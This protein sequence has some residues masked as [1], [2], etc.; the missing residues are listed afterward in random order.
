MLSKNE[1]FNEK[2]TIKLDRND[3]KF[4]INDWIYLDCVKQIVTF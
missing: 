1:K 4:T 3:W 2:I